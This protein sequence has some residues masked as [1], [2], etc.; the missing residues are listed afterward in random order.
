VF[1]G[2]RRAAR[3]GPGGP[4]HGGSPAEAALPAARRDHRA[5]PGAATSPA[6]PLRAARPAVA[7]HQHHMEV[8][9]VA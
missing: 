4:G 1:E 7:L 3:D 8:R 9:R 5:V 6:T 2:V